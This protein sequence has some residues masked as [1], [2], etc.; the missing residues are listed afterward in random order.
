MSS[1]ED[2]LS[3]SDVD[4]PLSDAPDLQD[5]A[6]ADLPTKKKQKKL[7]TQP[8]AASAE[9]EDAAE[10]QADAATDAPAPKKKKAS[11][12]KEAAAERLA[13]LKAKSKSKHEV[14]SFGELALDDRLLKVCRLSCPSPSLSP[15]VGSSESLCS[16]VGSAIRRFCSNTPTAHR[17]RWRRRMLDDY[18]Y[19]GT[20]LNGI[21]PP[22]KV[23]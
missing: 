8:A 16:V 1:S 4:E 3:G 6:D 15:F 22:F 5:A 20:S 23:C 7:K 13:V 19:T 14:K 21:R 11:K 9:P 12:G 2:D 17:C 18:N 10:G